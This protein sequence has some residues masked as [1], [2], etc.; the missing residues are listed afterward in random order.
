ML[1][2]DLTSRSDW[3]HVDL[4]SIF[5]LVFFSPVSTS[6]TVSLT[7][8]Y[9][10]QIPRWRV[11][12]P[13]RRRMESKKKQTEK[14]SFSKT[15]VAYIF[16]GIA[17][18]LVL[19]WREERLKL[20]FISVQLLVDGC[21]LSCFNL[22]QFARQRRKEKV[23]ELEEA[24]E[25]KR[26]NSS[27]KWMNDKDWTRTKSEWIG[28]WKKSTL[29]FPLRFHRIVLLFWIHYCNLASL[30][31]LMLLAFSRCGHQKIWFTS[32]VH[33]ALLHCSK[34]LEN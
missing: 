2:L 9:K 29:L 24:R 26:H 1:G 18:Q 33:F 16:M 11:E 32:E 31:S 25:K 3:L 4:T 17:S 28:L 19:L 6:L 13:K 21:C 15:V 12:I 5:T 27:L 34:T 23:E 10:I 20:V 8:T 30:H 14:E 7:N 22:I